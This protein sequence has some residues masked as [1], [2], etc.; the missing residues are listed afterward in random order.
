MKKMAGF[1]HTVYYVM[2][3]SG[4]GKSTIGKMLSNKLNCLALLGSMNYFHF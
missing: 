2:G 4:S 1:I 3:V